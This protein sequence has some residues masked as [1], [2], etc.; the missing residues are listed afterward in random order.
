MLSLPKSMY[1]Q[2]SAVGRN[3][4]ERPLPS[5]HIATGERGEGVIT[6]SKE[7]ESST[8][9]SGASER[10]DVHAMREGTGPWSGKDR[11]RAQAVESGKSG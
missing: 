7:R 6:I 9:D 3:G 8:G 4:C 5:L 1:T 2:Q 11:A 10:G